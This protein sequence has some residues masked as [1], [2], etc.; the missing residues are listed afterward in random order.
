MEIT[1]QKIQFT[2][3]PP[4][5]TWQKCPNRYQG[6]GPRA[7]TSCDS[8]MPGLTL[9]VLNTAEERMVVSELRRYSPTGVEDDL[10]LQL[11]PWEAARD[12]IA[13]VTSITRGNAVAGTLRFVPSGHGLTGGERLVRLTGAALP[14]DEPGSWEVG[15]LVLAPNERSPQMLTA[16]LAMALRELKRRREVNQFYAIASPAMARLWRRFGL[17]VVMNMRGAS[18]NPFVLVLGNAADVA[19][20]LH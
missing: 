4:A 6:N 14:L 12:D 17:K 5:F 19:L 13:V 9:Q 2:T 1:E 11:G 7:S 8:I 20:T 10:G 15:R 16:Y 18:G 3:R